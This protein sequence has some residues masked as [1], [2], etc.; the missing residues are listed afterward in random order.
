MA[1]AV[2]LHLLPCMQACDTYRYMHAT[3][4]IPHDD[5]GIACSSIAGPE[6]VS[7]TYFIFFILKNKNKN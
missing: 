5:D 2:R 4:R 3:E 6:K 1:G 7:L